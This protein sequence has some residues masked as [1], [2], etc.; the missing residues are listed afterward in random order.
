MDRRRRMAATWHSRRSQ[1]RWTSK[2]FG[3]WL[4]WSIFSRLAMILSWISTKTDKCKTFIAHHCFF[5]G[6][7]V[8]CDFKQNWFYNVFFQKLYETSKQFFTGKWTPEIVI[9]FLFLVLI[10]LFGTYLL[11][12][13]FAKT[14]SKLKKALETAK[15][16]KRIRDARKGYDEQSLIFYKRVERALEQRFQTARLACETPWSS[17][18]G[19]FNLERK[20]KTNRRQNMTRIFRQTPTR[21]ERCVN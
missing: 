21:V 11:W 12:L 19:V 17:L 10:L 16:N 20:H 9:R 5:K 7:I 13:V 4:N 8:N 15:E 2:T 6:V 3:A 1:S 14:S 18:T